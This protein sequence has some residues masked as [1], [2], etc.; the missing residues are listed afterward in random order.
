M[1]STKQGVRLWRALPL[2]AL[3][4]DDWHAI[5]RAADTI[6]HPRLIRPEDKPTSE[7]TRLLMQQIIEELQLFYRG[8]DA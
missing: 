1:V 3:M 5:L 7:N 8:S 6:G 4:S 2:T